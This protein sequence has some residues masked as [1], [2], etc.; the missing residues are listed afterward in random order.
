[1]F[2]KKLAH[3]DANE[4]KSAVSFC[5]QVAGLLPDMF[6]NFYLVKNHKIANKSATTETTE[7]NKHTFG[8]HRML[9]FFVA[10]LTKFENGQ[11]LCHKISHR[12]LVTTKLFSE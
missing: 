4:G 9:E 1:M 10:C 6:F 2:I 12:F 7:K 11:I 8:I 3:V 5:C